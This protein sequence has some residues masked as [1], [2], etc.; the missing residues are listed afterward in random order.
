[1]KLRNDTKPVEPENDDE[2]E[3]YNEAKPKKKLFAKYQSAEEA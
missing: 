3:N 1:M 2:E